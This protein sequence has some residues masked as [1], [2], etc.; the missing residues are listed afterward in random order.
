MQLVENVP[1]PSDNQLAQQQDVRKKN[2]ETGRS[3]SINTAISAF[4]QAKSPT[5]SAPQTRVKMKFS[6]LI[7]FY[8]LTF[9]FTE[10]TDKTA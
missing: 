7:K 6:F 5:D 10:R 4:N 8:D 2:I 9:S 1:K 3:G